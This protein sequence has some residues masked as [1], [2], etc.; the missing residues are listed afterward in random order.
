ML[1]KNKLNNFPKV[2][3]VGLIEN[4]DRRIELLKQFHKYQINQINFLLSERYP[5]NGHI[6]ESDY[7]DDN[8]INLRGMDCAVSHLKMIEQWIKETDDEY[9]FFCEDDLSLETVEYWNFTW[10]Q[11]YNNL[12]EDWECVQLF[13]I[14]EHFK[15]E[16]LELILR[17]WNFWGATAYIMKRDYAKKLIETYHKENRYILNPINETPNVCYWSDNYYAEPLYHKMPFVENILFTGIGKTYNCPLFVENI[18]TESTFVSGQKFGH[19]ESHE[20]ILN[21]WRSHKENEST[22]QFMSN[23]LEN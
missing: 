2:Y 17:Q 19:I 7:M 6:I 18:S 13:I 8:I 14:S 1:F 9:A 4:I 21:S 22:L 23:Q 11:F 20:S 15:V 12:P 5:E 16:C 3:C 10:E